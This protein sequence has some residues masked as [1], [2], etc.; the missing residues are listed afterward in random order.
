MMGLTNMALRRAL[1]VPAFPIA[2]FAIGF[3]AR[4]QALAYAGQDRGGKAGTH[5]V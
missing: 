1:K 2:D 3:E 4:T 5:A